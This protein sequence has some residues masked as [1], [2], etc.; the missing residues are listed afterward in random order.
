VNDLNE[1]ARAQQ[2]GV[3]LSLESCD[4]RG[5]C[6]Q[7][8]EEQMETTGRVI[9]LDLPRKALSAVID[10][11]RIEQVLTNLVTNAN[12]Y[13][14]P[15]APISVALRWQGS[16]AHIAVRDEGPGIPVD[17]LTHVFE[18]FYRVPGAQVL[19]GSASGLGL[20]LYICKSLIERH[21]GQIG[22]E[23]RSGHG[24]T[25]W[26]TLPLAPAVSAR[27]HSRDGEE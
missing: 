2:G 12:K 1:A 9:A 17:A 27:S 11:S 8:A 15:E 10:C 13:S 7:V 3:E 4:L 18:R 22:A 21:G 5:L 26:F 25:F 23:S 20:G 16:K 24:S 19:S 6:Q 14:P